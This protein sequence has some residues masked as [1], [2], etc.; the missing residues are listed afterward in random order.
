[1]T[2][3]ELER[4][5]EFIFKR[6]RVE[7]RGYETPCWIPTTKWHDGQGHKKF[8]LDGVTWYYHRYVYTILVKEI[9]VGLVLDHKCKVK[10]CC[11]PLHVEE[12]TQYVNITR[13]GVAFYRPRE[14]YLP[15]ENDEMA[16][17]YSELTGDNW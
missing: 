7:D 1:M 4:Q 16:N 3:E 2:L 17:V 6:I 15:P 8:Q 12:V 11:H 9:D 10:P 5:C 14:A 13:G